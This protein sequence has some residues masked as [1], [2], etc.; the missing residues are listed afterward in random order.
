MNHYMGLFKIPKICYKEKKHVL[1]IS[2]FSD[3][4]THE[5]RV[6]KY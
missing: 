3:N 6:A 5:K 1:A 4:L 2:V